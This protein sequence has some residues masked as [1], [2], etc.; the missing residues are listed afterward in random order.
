MEIFIS[1][2]CNQLS[3]LN[4]G[5]GRSADPAPHLQQVICRDRHYAF[6]KIGVAAPLVGPEECSHRLL[7][8]L[9]PVLRDAAV[10]L[11]IEHADPIRQ[12]IARLP[13]E[14]AQHVVQ[15][16][17]LSER[18]VERP[19]L[20]EEPSAKQTCR[21]VHIASIHDVRPR[22]RRK[23]LAVLMIEIAYAR[24]DEVDARV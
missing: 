1:P 3:R 5:T 11:A 4:G 24:V 7:S 15:V 19:N 21:E 10:V 2:L 12:E 17:R 16:L 23:A 9:L 14:Y 13:L 6:R 18:L 8:R 22:A 20:I